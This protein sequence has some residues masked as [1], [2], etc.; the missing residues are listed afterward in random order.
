MLDAERIIL[1]IYCWKCGQKVSVEYED[2]FVREQSRQIINRFDCPH[3]E[4]ANFVGLAGRLTTSWA[5]HG[6]KPKDLT[7]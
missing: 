5:G 7:T 2:T 4:E 6:R 1:P 3:C